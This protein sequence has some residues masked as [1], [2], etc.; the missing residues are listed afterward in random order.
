MDTSKSHL[1]DPITGSSAHGQLHAHGHAPPA[2][3]LFTDTFRSI[4]ASGIWNYGRGCDTT[5][6]GRAGVNLREKVA[7]D[8][9]ECAGDRD[10]RV[11]AL[12]R[13]SPL[14]RLESV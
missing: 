9:H 1:R 8:A 7:R 6:R 13:L 2:G 3:A 14:S 5:E 4:E 10:F 12:V 11:G